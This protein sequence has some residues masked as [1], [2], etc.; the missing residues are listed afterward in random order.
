MLKHIV[1]GNFQFIGFH[2]CKKLLELGNEVIGI[3]WR[4]EVNSSFED[5]CM[6]IGRN[7]NFSFFSIEE[8]NNAWNEDEEVMVYISYYDF[9]KVSAIGSEKTLELLNSINKKSERTAKRTFLIGPIEKEEEMKILSLQNEVC[10]I[11]LLP[12]VY[13]AWQPEGMAFQACIQGVETEKLSA[14]IREEYSRDAI[15]IE[16]LMDELPS[17]LASPLKEIV[18]E[19]SAEN[20]WDL[21]A[22]EIFPQEQI[23][24]S[25]NKVTE[26]E[27]NVE[28]NCMIPLRTSP[29]SGI[30]KQIDHYRMNQQLIGWK[31]F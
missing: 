25:R 13:G 19:S 28:T 16:D 1:V 17:I 18:I 2:L 12:T 24:V 23:E 26:Q 11:V 29:E 20:Q 7:D 15:Y 9:Y 10:K 5:K 14:I 4:S 27:P 31:R 6:E 30:A 21:C 3:D 8:W 22:K